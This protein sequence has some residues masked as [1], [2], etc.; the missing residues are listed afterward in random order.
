M[1]A[2]ARLLTALA[3]LALFALLAGAAGI[4]YLVFIWGADL[5]DYRQLANYEPPT[6]TRVHAGD[7][8]LLAEYAR[9]RRIFVPIEAI[10]ERVSHAFVAAEDQNF[11]RHP[12]IDLQGIGRAMVTNLQRLGGDR[13]PEGASTIT[14]QVAKNF[15]LSPER[16]LRRKLQEAVLT[17]TTEELLSRAKRNIDSCER[18]LR[19]AAEDIAKAREQ[20]AT[21]RDIALAVGKSPAWVNRL[22]KW[23]LSGYAGSAFTD[24]RVQGVNKKN[25]PPAPSPGAIESGAFTLTSAAGISGAAMSADYTCDGTLD[26]NDF[27]AYLTDFNA[28]Y[29]GR[30][31]PKCAP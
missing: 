14:Q 12:G 17:L 20:G 16:S 25:A 18:P 26:I 19:E 21:Q 4:Y 9:E 31:C 11:Y 15:L 29:T 22:L 2:F 13:R 28:S 30:P 7:G 6:L 24:R 27:N 8:R 1:R 23:R 3:G 5:P 10:P